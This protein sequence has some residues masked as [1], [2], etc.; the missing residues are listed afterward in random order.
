MFD[1]DKLQN[2]KDL[3]RSMPRTKENV[4]KVFDLARL[5]KEN[6]RTEQSIMNLSFNETF[7]ILETKLMGYCPETGTL[8][9]LQVDKEGRLVVA[10][11]K[12]K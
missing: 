5:L 7:A 11:A 1:R 3:L 4:K 9:T 10:P 8:I 2:L 12:A 6:E